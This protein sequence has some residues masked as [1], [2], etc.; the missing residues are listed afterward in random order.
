METIYNKKNPENW[1]QFKFLSTGKQI[2]K[3]IYSYNGIYTPI[4]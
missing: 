4:P 1:K 3:L 2:D